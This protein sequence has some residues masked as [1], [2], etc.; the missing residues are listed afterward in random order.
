MT[1]DERDVAL[2]DRIIELEQ[3]NQVMDQAFRDLEA[4]AKDVLRQRDQARADVSALRVLIRAW[5][6]AKVAAQQGV[7]CGCRYCA[8]FYS[9]LLRTEAS[10]A[11]AG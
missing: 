11:N 3:H 4:T 5:L 1:D 2:S 7:P 10:Y 9:A 6:T 8:R